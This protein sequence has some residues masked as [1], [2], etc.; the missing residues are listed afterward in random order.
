MICP[1]VTLKDRTEGTT[2]F[3]T[4]GYGPLGSLTLPGNTE[5]ATY[6]TLIC[7]LRNGSQGSMLGETFIS[8]FC[9][10]GIIS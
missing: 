3:L 6:F 9:T 8:T 5:P 2:R 10:S 4:S 1:D 7:P